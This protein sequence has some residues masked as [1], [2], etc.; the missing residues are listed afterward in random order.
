MFFPRNPTLYLYSQCCLLCGRNRGLSKVHVCQLWM[1]TIL[2]I[3]K[4]L[5]L[6]N[7]CLQ[8]CKWQKNLMINYRRLP[9]RQFV[10][11]FF[12]LLTSVFSLVVCCCG[13]TVVAA[14]ISPPIQFRNFLSSSAMLLHTGGWVGA[15]TCWRSVFFV[16]NKQFHM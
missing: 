6:C 3:S 7:H 9:L 13:P 11:I 14:P 10:N 16:N 12:F 1:F 2:K 8:I 15:T 5:I 4:Y